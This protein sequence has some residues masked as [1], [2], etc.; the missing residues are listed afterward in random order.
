MNGVENVSSLLNSLVIPPIIMQWSVAVVTSFYGGIGGWSLGS[1]LSRSINL[2]ATLA[3][4]HDII[5]TNLKSTALNS[6]LVS[7]VADL[8]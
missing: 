3:C 8:I 6:I 7:T 5:Q 1:S 2:I 4:H